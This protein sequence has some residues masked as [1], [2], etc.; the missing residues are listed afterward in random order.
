MNKDDLL[1]KLNLYATAPD[2]DNIRFKEMIKGALLTCPELLYALH[3]K[4]YESE[5][6]DD[7]GNINVEY[8]EH[9]ELVEVYG[10]WSLY[11]N[12]NIKPYLFLPETQTTS[13]HYLCYKAGFREIP[14]FNSVDKIMQ[15]TFVVLCDNKDAIDKETGIARHDL[16][17]SII[18]ERFNWSNIFGLQCKLVSNEESTTDTNYITRTLVFESTIPNSIVKTENGVT[19]FINNKVR[20]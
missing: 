12:D 16:I 19:Q 4:E 7:E 17:G 13:K 15:V 9:G 10:D 5:L 1:L 6:F 3:N 2:D 20:R 14:R 11:Y 8:D 18:R